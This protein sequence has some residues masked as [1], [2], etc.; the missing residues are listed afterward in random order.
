MALVNVVVVGLII[1]LFGCS[2]GS[3]QGPTARMDVE[4]KKRSR[5]ASGTSNSPCGLKIALA[6]TSLDPGAGDSFVFHEDGNHGVHISSFCLVKSGATGA[7]LR[8]K[9][10]FSERVALRVEHGR[11]RYRDVSFPGI[12]VMREYSATNRLAFVGGYGAEG[13]RSQLMTTNEFGVELESLGAASKLSAWRCGEMQC[14]AGYIRE[15]S[16]WEFLNLST[17]QRQLV[18]VPSQAARLTEVQTMS[19]RDIGAVWWVSDSAPLRLRGALSNHEPSL[20]LLL[21]VVV[22]DVSAEIYELNGEA[23]LWDGQANLVIGK[24]GELTP[25]RVL[26][27]PKAPIVFFSDESHWIDAS[28]SGEGA[29]SETFH[30][31]KATMESCLAGANQREYPRTV[32]VFRFGT[33]SVLLVTQPPYSHLL[34]FESVEGNQVCVA[35]ELQSRYR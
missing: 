34:S 31:L 16:H 35:G 18:N 28:L 6:K 2:S 11:L 21:D 33:A 1:L 15:T 26:G 13:L 7:N 22:R 24:R 12:V 8:T 19:G 20:L 14:I 3:V 9:E 30:S 23:V 5:L 27:A 10:I 29:V 4:L 17:R 32:K 25:L